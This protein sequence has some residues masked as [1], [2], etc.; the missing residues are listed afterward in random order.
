MSPTADSDRY[1]GRHALDRQRTRPAAWEAVSRVLAYYRKAPEKR[2]YKYCGI[3]PLK[4]VRPRSVNRPSLP[5]RSVL[6][7]RGSER[8][9]KTRTD[10][11]LATSMGG[12]GVTPGTPLDYASSALTALRRVWYV[13]ISHRHMRIP[14]FWVDEDVYTIPLRRRVA[15]PCLTRV[16]Y[17]VQG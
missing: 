9:G 11:R 1:R 4:G 6:L 12:S 14:S 13:H 2:S 7:A 15:E 8:A 10:A 17:T 16:G 3:R 5:P